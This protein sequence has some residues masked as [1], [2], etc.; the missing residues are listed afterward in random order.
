MTNNVAVNGN[1]IDD[2]VDSQIQGCLD[3]DNLKSFFLY[4]GAGSGKTRSLVNALQWIRTTYG[5][6]L[7]LRGQRIGVITY[8]NAACDEIKERIE[9]NV[10]IQ[11]STIH[12]FAWSLIGSYHNDIRNWLRTNLAAEITELRTAQAKGRVGTKA[13]AEREASIANKTRRLE[14]IET[15]KQFVYNPTADNRGRDALSHT[16]VISMASDFLLTKPTLQKVLVTQYPILLIDESQDTNRYLMD[17]LFAVQKEHQ[18]GLCLGL[19]GDMMQRI[20]TDG[21]VGLQEAVPEVWAKPIKQLNHR[22]P[23]RVLDLL[24]KMRNEVDGQQ[25]KGRADKPEG[26]VRLFL[27]PANTED[28][29][30]AEATVATRM[31]EI[32][33]DDGWKDDYK[34]LILEHHM[35]AK[36]DGFGAMFELL[37][38]VDRFR[39]GLLDGSLPAV[40]FFARQVLPVVE[41]MQ[42]G[43]RFAATAVVRKHSPFLDAK[44]LQIQNEQLKQ[45][46]AA[47]A[48]VDALM[49]LWNDGA[50]PTFGDVLGS[51]HESGLF[52]LPDVLNVIASRAVT[53]PT[54]DAGADAVADEERDEAVKAWDEVMATPFDQ[55]AAYNRYVTGASPFDTHQGIKGREFP[56]VMVVIDDEEA[57]G[58]LFSYEKLFG[59]KEKSTT[60]IKNEEQG[61]E[62]TIDRTRRLFYV[63]CSRTEESLAIVNYT[64]DPVKVRSRVLAAGWFGE[65]EIIAVDPGQTV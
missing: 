57:R 47:K 43:D 27:L 58:F 61:F 46:T 13:A 32:T 60:D 5:R 31:V 1:E 17:A 49:S 14:Y 50:K 29:Q 39:T 63:T 20:Y 7:W 11:V 64:G 28:K 35:A 62:T 44:T 15:A 26:Y 10:L 8:T 56:R 37:Y 40:G 53:A 25:Q 33:G 19:F 52:S 23:G 38:K 12:S 36:R 45:L 30:G 54:A 22:C 18:A 42:R 59:V 16:E 3:L 34:A 24:N 55:I 51:I 6:R 48:G 2:V 41:A 21:K 4:A 65:N 9:F